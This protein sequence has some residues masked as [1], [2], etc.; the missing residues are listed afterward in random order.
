MF[1]FLL[2]GIIAVIAFVVLYACMRASAE[3]G[4]QRGEWHDEGEEQ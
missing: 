4:I 1:Y 2:G 3:M